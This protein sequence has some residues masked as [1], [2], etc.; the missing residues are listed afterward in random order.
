MPMD[1]KAATDILFARIRPEDLA[2]EI[3]CSLQM[4]RQARMGEGTGGG[5][6]LPPP[7]WEQA[8]RHLAERHAMDLRTLSKSVIAKDHS[9]RPGLRRVRKAQPLQ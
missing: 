1:F 6:R 2:S 4:I 7:G 8:V 3:G 5:R 9:T